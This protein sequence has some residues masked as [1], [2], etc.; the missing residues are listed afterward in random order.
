MGEEVVCN[1]HAA[2]ISL[3]PPPPIIWEGVSY[4]LPPVIGGIIDEGGGVS[5]THC[6]LNFIYP[7]HWGGCINLFKNI[8]CIKNKLK[9]IL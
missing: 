2:S 1:P 7:P 4:S 9:Y 3:R 8:K 5:S 6:P